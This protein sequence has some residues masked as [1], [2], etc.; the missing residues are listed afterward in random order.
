MATQETKRVG[1]LVVLL[2]VVG[3][4]GIST[5]AAQRGRGPGA[6]DGGAFDWVGGATNGEFIGFYTSAYATGFFTLTRA[7]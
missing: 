6:Q 5:A 1:W 2:V 3:A 7:K 4:A